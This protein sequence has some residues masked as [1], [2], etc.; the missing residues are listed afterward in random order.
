MDYV[1]LMTEMILRGDSY[2]RNDSGGYSYEKICQKWS[3]RQI[4][5]TNWVWDITMVIHMFLM[6]L[7]KILFCRPLNV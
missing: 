5:T 3:G 6:I 4:G 7:L 2:D 1:I